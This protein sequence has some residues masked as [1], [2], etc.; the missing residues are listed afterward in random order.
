MPCNLFFFILKYLGQSS[1]GDLLSVMA[2]QA[3]IHGIVSRNFRSRNADGD[4]DHSRLQ[5]HS[6][7]SCEDWDLNWECALQPHDNCHGRRGIFLWK[8]VLGYCHFGGSHHIR[9]HWV[10]GYA[11]VS[12]FPWD[13]LYLVRGMFCTSGTSYHKCQRDLLGEP[14]CSYDTLSIFPVLSFAPFRAQHGL[15]QRQA[16]NNSARIKKRLQLELLIGLHAQNVQKSI[17]WLSKL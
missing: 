5:S 3:A 8:R 14:A 9:C 1:D 10:D 12:A 15:Q 6:E 4:K 2:R 16:P 17:P 13:S 11:P 7:G